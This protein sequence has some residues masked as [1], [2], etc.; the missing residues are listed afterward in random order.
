MKF[1]YQE[2]NYWKATLKITAPDDEHIDRGEQVRQVLLF[3]QQNA[4]TLRGK[5]VFVYPTDDIPCVAL[6]ALAV[7]IREV[8]GRMMFYDPKDDTFHPMGEP[9][10]RRSSERG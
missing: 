6:T 1:T 9:V 4:A 8:G 7:D 5:D 10:F 3:V 2:L